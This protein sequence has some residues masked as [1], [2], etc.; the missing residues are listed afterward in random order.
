MAEVFGICNLCGHMGQVIETEAE[1]G[2]TQ[3]ACTPTCPPQPTTKKKKVDPFQQFLH[4]LSKAFC[5]KKKVSGNR[6]SRGVPGPR[7]RKN[8]SFNPH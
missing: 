5:G 8:R 1:G 6:K 4:G 7:M 2:K 3:S